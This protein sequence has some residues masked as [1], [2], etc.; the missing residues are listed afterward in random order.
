ML[1]HTVYLPGFSLT[2]HRAHEFSAEL[3]AEV[4]TANIK[5]TIHEIIQIGNLSNSAQARNLIVLKKRR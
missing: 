4:F 2:H 3:D 1:A 5:K